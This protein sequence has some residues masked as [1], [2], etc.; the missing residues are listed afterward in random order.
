M[1]L[2]AVA[3]DASSDGAAEA[4]WRS[5]PLH[6]QDVLLLTKRHLRGLMHSDQAYFEASL[7]E[8]NE[9]ELT[10]LTGLFEGPQAA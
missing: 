2:A 6:E 8:L 5:D 10:Y 7:T 1:M 3:S 4:Y 9:S